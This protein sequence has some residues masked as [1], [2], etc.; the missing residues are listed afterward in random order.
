MGKWEKHREKGFTGNSGKMNRKN[1]YTLIEALVYIAIFAVTINFVFQLYYTGDRMIS[2]G[3][4]YSDA[5]NDAQNFM[6][7]FKKDVRNSSG[8]ISSFENFQNSEETLILQLDN[9]IVIYAF[10]RGKKTLERLKIQEGTTCRTGSWR[11]AD[12]GFLC[13]S[14]SPKTITAHFRPMAE[15]RLFKN[16]DFSLV[17]GIRNEE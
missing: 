2:R 11:F 1:G 13:S 9:R 16:T 4:E 15:G 3:R 5:L 14:E 10:N 12:A 6:D 8:T 17:A 7:D